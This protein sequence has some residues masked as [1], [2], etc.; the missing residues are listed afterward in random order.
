MVR[1]PSQHRR[2]PLPAFLLLRSSTYLQEVVAAW[3]LY[4]YLSATRSL[5]CP[6]DNRCAR[7]TR[8]TP[9]SSSTAPVRLRQNALRNFS[10]RERSVL[11]LRTTRS[12]RHFVRSRSAHSRHFH[13]LAILTAPGYRNHLQKKCVCQ[14]A[15]GSRNEGP[16]LSDRSHRDVA[17]LRTS[18]PV[19]KSARKTLGISRLS[20][21]ERAATNSRKFR[22]PTYD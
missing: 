15:P 7:D 3:L 21:L 20:N 6:H 18:D 8:P 10:L 13:P 16:T 19:E 1:Q 9:V 4:S 2:L 12:R 22:S 11:L 14:S 17:R 5:P